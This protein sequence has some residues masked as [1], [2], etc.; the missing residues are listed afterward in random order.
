[1]HPQGPQGETG[2]T[3]ATGETGP[4]RPQGPQGPTGATGAT[5]A[6]G[7]Q[8]PAG[9]GLVTGAYLQLEKGAP[10]PAGFI[11]LGTTAIN[12]RDLTG[13]QKSIT[14]DLYRKN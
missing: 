12:Y 14:V 11:L 2:A 4:A 1:V 10:A 6:Q 7:P 5:G 13:R 9:A 8:G 3:G